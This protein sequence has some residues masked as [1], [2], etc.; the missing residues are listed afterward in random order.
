M[1]ST[2]GG[3]LFCE[4]PRLHLYSRALTSLRFSTFCNTLELAKV[5]VRDEEVN[6]HNAPLATTSK[7]KA[8][9]QPDRMRF[10]P[11]LPLRLI[12]SNTSQRC[13]ARSSSRPTVGTKAGRRE[14]A[15]LVI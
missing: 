9:T 6:L 3:C 2:C 4:P 8:P 10:K 15:L 11:V 12:G 14:R 1:G 5:I 13:C 7:G